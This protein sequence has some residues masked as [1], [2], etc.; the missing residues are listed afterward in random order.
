MSNLI[1]YNL[2]KDQ[3]KTGDGLG[4]QNVG[5]IPSIIKWKTKDDGPIPLSHWG[6]II[7]FPAY[8][9][10]ENRRYTVEADI[11][12]FNTR[13]FSDYIKDYKGHIY[14]YPLKDEWE[15]YRN[16]IGEDILSMT[17]IGYDFLGVCAQLFIK[18]NTNL[19]YL[20]CSEGWQIGTQNTAL[21]LC[22]YKDK[23][24][25]TPTGMWKLGC[26]KE[27]MELF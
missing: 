9:G 27:P 4:F 1:N 17:G 23:T 25:L 10:A 26:Y 7:R 22:K 14:W 12:G 24:A 5:I 13:L 15:P 16:Q 11:D 8:E 18:I 20:F 6:G 21:E 3:M 19:R 2:L